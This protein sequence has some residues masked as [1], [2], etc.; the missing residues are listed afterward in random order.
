MLKHDL[1]LY[2]IFN[3]KDQ[4]IRELF[5]EFGQLKKAAVHYDSSGRSLGKA[6]VIFFKI[7]DSIRAMKKYN[8]VPL[9][10]KFAFL[11]DVDII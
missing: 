4:D 11:L 6:E 7:N 8:G 1:I 9:D 3:P 2:I 10:G 5:S